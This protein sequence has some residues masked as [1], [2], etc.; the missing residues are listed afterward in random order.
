MYL[1]SIRIENF[2]GI[3][4]GSV[5]FDES[6]VL[7]GEND[8]GRSSI[9]EALVL[10]LGPPE[11]NFERRLRPAHFHRT[12]QGAVGPLRIVLRVAEKGPRNWVLPPGLK[13]ALRFS[14]GQP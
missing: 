7:I 10:L 3:R 12:S 2:R 14:A 11:E 4:E 9:V 1:H 6:T 8:S 5:T 13:S